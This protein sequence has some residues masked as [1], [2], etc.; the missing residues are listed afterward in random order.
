MDNSYNVVE[1]LWGPA[2][3]I[4]RFVVV[5]ARRPGFK[6]AL[7]NARYRVCNVSFDFADGF[8]SGLITAS[9]AK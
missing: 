3:T 9:R 4:G 5:P 8:A 2:H 1:V 7:R 6:N